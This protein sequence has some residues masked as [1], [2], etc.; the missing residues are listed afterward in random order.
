M[1]IWEIDKNFSDPVSEQSAEYDSFRNP[2]FRLYGVM[3]DDAEK[4]FCR[5]PSEAAQNINGNIAF[6]NK[7]TAGGRLGFRTNSQLIRI[8]VRTGDKFGIPLQSEAMSVAFS[9]YVD[10][11]FFKLMLPD[12]QFQVRDGNVFE[13]ECRFDCAHMRN[14]LLYF[15]LYG[16]VRDLEIGLCR[17]CAVRMPKPYQ[18]RKPVLFYG[19]S[20]TQGCCASRPGNDYCSMLSQM[21]GFDFLNFG[22]SGNAKAEDKMADYIASLDLSAFVYDYDYNA[23]SVE[24]LAARHERFFLRLRK[25]RPDL[26]VLMLTKPN[27][28]PSAAEFCRRRQVIDAT[29]AHAAANGDQNVYRLEYRSLYRGR[30]AEAHTVDGCHPNDYGFYQMAKEIAPILKQ[31]LRLQ[32]DKK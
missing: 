12:R 16:F 27:D 20:T 4:T 11:R 26:P 18:F 1:N 2:V 9:L 13:A 23:E 15:P 10:G 19:S 21:L 7:C 31:I 6:L 8:R 30:L 17:G 28:E 14:I 22:F 3:Y 32:S 24:E 25:S 5:M 29:F